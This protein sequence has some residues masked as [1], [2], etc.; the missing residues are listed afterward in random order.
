MRPR[1]PHLNPLLT[2]LQYIDANTN[3]YKY[4]YSHQYTEAIRNQI[5]SNEITIGTFM[6]ILSMSK[7]ES[8]YCGYVV[9]PV[10]FFYHKCSKNIFYCKL[11]YN[12][13]GGPVLV[14]RNNT[15]G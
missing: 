5:Y 2:W 9:V 15:R 10:F 7:F 1:G 3:I 4:L 8:A 11:I 6:E 13:V 12:I 14:T